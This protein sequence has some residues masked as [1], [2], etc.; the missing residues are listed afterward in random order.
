MNAFIE[1]SKGEANKIII[2]TDLANVVGFLTG[3]VDS[4][5]K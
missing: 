5:K 2:P 4:I 1:A 3:V